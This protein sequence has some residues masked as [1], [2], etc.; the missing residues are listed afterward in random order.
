MGDSGFAY[1]DET[2]L[3]ALREGLVNML[4]HAD[5]FG[6]M[7]STIRVFSNRIIFQNPGKFYINISELPKSIVSKPRNPIIARIFRW[8]KLAENAG[9]GFDK[10]LAWKHKVEFET[11]VDYSEVTFFLDEN[12][13]RTVEETETAEKTVE[14]TVEETETTEKTVEKILDI[15][16]NNPQITQKE[17]V[18]M[19]GLTRRGVEWNLAKLK[20]EGLIERVGPNKGGHWRLK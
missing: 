12:D 9:F 4:M 16:T 20:A 18:E 17:L 15:I 14:E 5:Y 6:V 13:Q 10:M 2:Q 19:T 3:N 1:E 11:Y 8:A 7:H